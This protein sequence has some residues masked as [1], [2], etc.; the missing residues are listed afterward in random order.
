LH[1]G[2]LNNLQYIPIYF[3]NNNRAVVVAILSGEEHMKPRREKLPSPPVK[4]ETLPVPPQVPDFAKV[5]NN[6]T[7]IGFFTASSKRSRQESEKVITITEKGVERRVTI[8]AGGNLGLP[9]TQ[10]QDYWLALMKLVSEHVQRVGKLEN[11]FQFT[12]A[13]LIKVLGQVHGGKNYQAVLEWADVMTFTGIKGGV[14]DSANKQ[15]I[16]DRTHALHRFVCAGKELP[17]GKIADKNYIWFSD[18]QLDNINSGKLI[19]IELT[20]YIQLKTN[21]ARNLVPHLQEW[22]FASQRDGRFE[23]QYEDICRLLGLR[24]YRHL[25]EIE[26]KLGPSLDELV[27]HGY[28]SQWAIE[29]MAKNQGYK[30]V[31]WHGAKYHT[32]RKSRQESKRLVDS[33]SGES[34]GRRRP[35]QQRLQLDSPAAAPVS[36]APS[37]AP[38]PPA[39]PPPPPPPQKAAV[40][41]ALL[42]ELVNRG[43]GEGDARKVLAKVAPEQPVMDQLEYADAVIRQSRGKIQNP[44]GFYISRLQDNAPN[45]A[46]FETSAARKIREEAEAALALAFAE[47]RL[48]QMQAEE[49]E[50][51]R[52]DAQIDALPA[53]TRLALFEKAKAQLLAS[54]PGMALFFKAHPEDAINDGA[55]RGKMRQIFLGRTYR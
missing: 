27:A 2:S 48:A 39:A 28:L 44:Q 18:W 12:T 46:W 10:D 25:S 11:P 24:I 41:E 34:S 1:F 4:P 33:E 6:L 14:Y 36:P 52:R 5:D 49:N 53:A 35:R 40:D 31:M 51:I 47:E 20:T 30:L 29:P 23:K 15:W 45:P 42:A 21:I 3:N 26:R 9:I 7:S 19:P 37:A 50:R 55:V 22:L 16:V 38:E 43:V 13:E 32:D 54:Y 17:N 8:L